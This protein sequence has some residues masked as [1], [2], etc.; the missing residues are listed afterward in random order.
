MSLLKLYL[1]YFSDGSVLE[2]YGY[3]K[4]AVYLSAAELH[5]VAK[6]TRVCE[7]GDW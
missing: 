6:V 7:L 1:A 4:D 2:L 3:G 5:P